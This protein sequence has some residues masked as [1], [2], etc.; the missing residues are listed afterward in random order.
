MAGL[1]GQPGA[2]AQRLAN[3]GAERVLIHPLSEWE[4]LASG[5]L[6]N[7]PTVTKVLVKVCLCFVKVKRKVWKDREVKQ[8]DPKSSPQNQN[9]K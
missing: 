5:I 1:Y 9:G 7:C 4:E 3:I 2:L 6:T 8:S